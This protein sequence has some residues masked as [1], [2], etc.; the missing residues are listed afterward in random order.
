MGLW[1]IWDGET[2]VETSEEE[3]VKVLRTL[4]ASDWRDM[5][6]AQ[7]RFYEHVLREHDARSEDPSHPFADDVMMR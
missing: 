2:W 3:A 4:S 5:R 6:P 7:R 1:A